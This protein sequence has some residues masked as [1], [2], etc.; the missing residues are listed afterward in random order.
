[1]T[2][3]TF[4]YHTADIDTVGGLPVSCT[5]I[6]LQQCTLGHVVY[7]VLCHVTGSDERTAGSWSHSWRL[8]HC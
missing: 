4:Q 5:D 7:D 3:L 6:L 1:M 2:L 8:S